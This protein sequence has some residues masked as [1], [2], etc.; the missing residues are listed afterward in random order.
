M[1]YAFSREATNSATHNTEALHPRRRNRPLYHPVIE[2]N[3]SMPVASSSS[4]R[5]E[6]GSRE[7]EERDEEVY[8][9]LSAW[10]RYCPSL[11]EVKLDQS[12]VWR[13][14]HTAD[15]WAKREHEVGDVEHTDTGIADMNF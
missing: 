9:A 4:M 3:Y 12:G 11:L 15:V 13:R 8:D 10:K 1:Y 7:E 6:T 2:N 14:A 5:E